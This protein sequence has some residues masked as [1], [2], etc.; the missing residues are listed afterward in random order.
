MTK[1]FRADRL[2][3]QPGPA[4]WNAILPP[5]RP[6]EPLN[7]D[8]TADVA[9]VGAGIAG[10]SAALRL[11]Q[12]EPGTRILVV[13]AGRVAEGPAGRNSGFMID[14]PHNLSSNDYA[15][16]G[17]DT[18]ARQTDL[19]RR[20]IRF[21]TDAAAQAGL[22]ESA[23]NPCG[24][25]NAA[26]TESGHRHNLDYARHLE[27]LGEHHSMLD[28]AQMRDLTGTDYYQSG[29][30]T[31][32]TVLI[33]PARYVRALCGLLRDSGV[34]VHEDSAVRSIRR[35]GSA[36]SLDCGKAR[37]S[38]AK[39]VLA[40]NG[41]AESFGFFSGRLLHV[42]T[43]ASMTEPFDARA[44]GLGGASSWGV[45][46]ADPAGSTVRRVST[47]E[48]ERIVVRTRFTCNPS[49]RAGARQVTAAGRLHD[50]AF[51]VRFPG[52]ADVAM[53]YR[54]A[55]HLCLSW[56]DVP[57]FGEIEDGI[58]AACCQNGLGLARGTLSGMA[59]ADLAMGIDSPEVRGLMM[60]EAPKKL[61]PRPLTWVG[62]NAIMRWKEWTAGRE[63]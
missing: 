20:A 53:Q 27:G 32:G 31:P 9:I 4:A 19:N 44:V 29:L 51:K 35:D 37:V 15:G 57:A 36:W 47:P 41:H 63:C 6:C 30:F 45:T 62:A 40:V 54:W 46:P 58:Y 34:G 21:A 16:E 25:I 7:K 12:V 55:G 24:K 2:P 26:A 14:L 13:D 52:L 1:V 43:Y 42:F 39:V 61:P 50:R 28:A 17:T 11:V 22:D 23:F 48:G 56:N 5:Q 8:A 60:Q 38:A 59:A 3:V 10:L 33:Q 49:M 18:D